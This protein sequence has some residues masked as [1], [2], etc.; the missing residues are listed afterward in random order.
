MFFLGCLDDAACFVLGVWT[1]RRALS[2]VF[3]RRG[4]LFF[5]CLDDAMCFVLVVWTT[6]RAFSWFFG[7]RGVLFRGCLDDEV[8]FGLAVWMT[9]CAFSWL[10]GRRGVLCLG[11]L[12]AAVCISPRWRRRRRGLH[13]RLLA[14]S[15]AAEARTAICLVGS[16]RRRRDDMHFS[17]GG[18][19][20]GEGADGKYVLAGMVAEART[21]R[22]ALE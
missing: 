11:C 19:H 17:F 13:I 20:G 6:R 4:V 9:R 18:D 1:T 8:C 12:D 22:S 2:W 14:G 21:A 5:G 3:G 15:T 10:F 7:R 16:R